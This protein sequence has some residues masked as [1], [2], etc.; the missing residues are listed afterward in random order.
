MGNFANLCLSFLPFKAL[1]TLWMHDSHDS[2]WPLWA[3]EEGNSHEF[4]C[5][6][7]T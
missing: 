7:Y 2:T 4:G 5:M 6:K 1:D 3:A